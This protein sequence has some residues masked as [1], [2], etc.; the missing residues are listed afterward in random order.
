MAGE[1]LSGR[2]FLVARGEC[3]RWNCR[4]AGFDALLKHSIRGDS[5]GGT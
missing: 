4:R 3:R 5:R 1:R 2:R